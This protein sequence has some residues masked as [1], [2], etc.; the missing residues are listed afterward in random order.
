MPPRNGVREA[1][2]SGPPPAADSDSRDAA[3]TGQDGV[4]I[5][6]SYEYQERLPTG[7]ATDPPSAKPAGGRCG[8]ATRRYHRHREPSGFPT[9]FD[10]TQTESQGGQD[11]LPY[12]PLGAA[13]LPGAVARS[14]DAVRHLRRARIVN[15]A[16]PPTACWCQ[17][18]ANPF[19]HFNGPKNDGS[20]KPIVWGY[21]SLARATGLVPA[22]TGS[23]SDC[24]S[25]G[26]G[27]LIHKA[28]ETPLAKAVCRRFS[29]N[30]I[31]GNH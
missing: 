26:R 2:R 24:Q 22:T 20:R 6:T 17:R 12:G 30:D 3:T 4:V 19:R 16:A 15:C 10:P 1:V 29:T 21:F 11:E 14:D 8:S 28:L 5:G 25:G 13:R 31:E 27:M 23:T 18:I 7:A 9:P